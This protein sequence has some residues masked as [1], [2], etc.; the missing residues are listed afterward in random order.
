MTSAS[1]CRSSAWSLHPNW[2][3]TAD[4]ARPRATTE[5]SDAKEWDARS[6]RIG[7]LLEVALVGG[8]HSEPTP[9]SGGDHVDVDHVARARAAR[10]GPDPVCF[11]VA[12]G[13]HVAAPQE[14]PQ[15]RLAP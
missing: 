2:R 1:H 4:A 15:L 11:V 14:A 7:D 13:H 3:P 9:M 12:E 5:R 6:E 10:Q 8:H